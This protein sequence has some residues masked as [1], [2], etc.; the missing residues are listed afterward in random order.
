MQP[1]I[2]VV[3][4]GATGYTGRLCARYMAQTIPPRAKAEAEAGLTW[5]LAGRSRAKLRALHEELGL[6][7]ASCQLFPSPHT[8]S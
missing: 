4:L 8:Q 7:E 2:D 5:A 1:P 3:L 6:D